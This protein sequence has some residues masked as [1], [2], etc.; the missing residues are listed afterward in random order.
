MSTVSVV[1]LAKG[2][3]AHLRNVL[4]GLER[5]TQKPAEFVV[6]VMQDALYDLPEVGFPVR[7]IRV[8]GTE[9]PL[10]AARNRG[11]A[12]SSGDRIAFLDVDCIPTPGFVAEYAQGLSALDG[13]LMGEVLHLPEHATFGDWDY[14]GLARVAEKHSD[15]RGP[16]ASGIEICSDYRCFWSL[17]FAISRATFEAV[18]GFDERYTGYGGEDTD[19]GKILDRRGIPIA[20]MKGALAYHQ[21]HPHHMPPI[22][23][24]DSVVRNAELFEAKWGYRTMGHWLHAFR[25]M[26]LIDDTPDRPI[27]ILRRPDAADLALTGQQSHQP[28]TNS[29]SVIR[30]LEARAREAEPAPEPAIAPVTA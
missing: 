5:Q 21:Y 25:V 11:V 22:H 8:E 24:L 15:R 18:G 17:N 26:G 10:A 14:D 19:L 30:H 6:A 9:L 23:H 4:L 12:A 1:T 7:Q 27:R 29:A 13:L 20:W 28:Y 3:P 2:R 16:P